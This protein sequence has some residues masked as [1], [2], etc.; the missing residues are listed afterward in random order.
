MKLFILILI[1]SNL[2]LQAQTN[3]TIEGNFP[4]FPD[5]AYELK[6]F[7]GLESITLSSSQSD[8]K[9]RFTLTYPENYKG[10]AHLYMNGSYQTLLLLNKENI[11]LHWEDLTNRDDL[12]ITG[13]KEYDAFL[14]GMKTF[15]QADSRLAGL[16]Y[17]LP[18]Y[19]QD[20]IKQKWLAEEME[21][22]DNAF[23]NYVKS[24]P[25]TLFS[26]QYLLALGLITQMPKTVETYNW[27]APIH[28]DEFEAIDFK[29]LHSSGIYKEL[30]EGYTFLVER[31]PLEEI[32]PLLNKAIDKVIF[33]LK[34]EPATQQD[35][36]QF[37]FELLE[38]RS[39][40][41]SAEHL[42]LA[43]FNQKDGKLSEKA[44]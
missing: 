41:K 22:T 16:Y 34:E 20:T 39:L 25:D 12:K 4:N 14:Q 23:P 19:E 31:F 5:S 36:A 33:E 3:Y 7:S 43:M 18:L 27:R 17:L 6:G 28:I 11:Q 10:A 29:Q 42:S 1:I 9:G 8:K 37:W 26:R 13:S 30:I 35:I 32:E 40:F 24:L 38:K 2:Y 44:K 21:Y 15:Q